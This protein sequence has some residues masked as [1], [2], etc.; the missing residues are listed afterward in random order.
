MARRALSAKTGPSAEGAPSTTSGPRDTVPLVLNTTRN[1]TWRSDAFSAPSGGCQH[2]LMRS[3]SAS[4]SLCV[5]CAAS[6]LA[7]PSVAFGLSSSPVA[8]WRCGARWSSSSAAIL[9]GLNSGGFLTGFFGGIGFGSAFA[10]FSFLSSSFLISLAISSGFFSSGF[11]SGFLSSALASCFSGFFGSGGFG[12]SGGFCDAALTSCFSVSFGLMSSLSGLGSAFFS[13]K[14]LGF[15]TGLGASLAPLVIC[16]KSFSEIMSTGNASGGV[17]SSALPD[18]DRVAHT[19]TATWSPAEIAVAFRITALLARSALLEFRH[20][21]DA[22]EAGA[23]EPAHHAH[24][25][26]VVDLL[27]AAHVDARLGAAA[28]LRHGLELGDQLVDVD[29][30]ILQEHLPLLVDRDGERLL[31]LVEALGLRLRQVDRHADRQKRRRDHED[32]EQHQHH[33]D[34]RRDVDLR[35]DA[36]AMTGAAA[37]ADGGSAGVHGHRKTP[38]LRMILPENRCPLFGIMR[39][40]RS[41]IWRDRIA[42]NSS[43]N[44]SRRCVSLFTSA[45]N[46]L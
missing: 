17:A 42:A 12:G 23:G 40:P 5:S 38:S 43:A 34:H 3:R 21:R 39:Y 18:S 33:V 25:R 31:V 10:S 4:I 41:S 37:R 36:A 13:T 2:C 9:S 22:V 19:S 44:P 24:H 29:L 11:G 14:G 20:Q 7:R 27:V 32:D 30:R 16:E 15:S 8:A 46:L 26:P 45:A 6:P 35:H 28:R 1:T